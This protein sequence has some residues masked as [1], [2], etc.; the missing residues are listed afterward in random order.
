MCTI[1]S[2]KYGGKWESDEELETLFTRI[3]ANE[4]VEKT[5]RPPS[6]YIV[7]GPLAYS[8]F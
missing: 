5:Q 2:G 4:S 6:S 1:M 7:R 3:M 8:A